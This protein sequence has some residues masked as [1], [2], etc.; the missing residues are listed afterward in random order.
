MRKQKTNKVHHSFRRSYREDYIRETKAPTLMEHA[1]NS[2]KIL[3]KNWRIFGLLLLISIVLFAVLVG[4]MSESTYSRFQAAL[5]S[6]S[7]TSNLGSFARAGLILITAFTTGGFSTSM[8]EVSSVFLV[9]IFLFVWLTTIYFLRQIKNKEKPVF[10]AGLYNSM[11]PL[12]STFSVLC[13]IIIEMIPIFVLTIVYSAA[14]RTNFL[15]TPFYALLFLLFAILLIILTLYLLSSSIIALVAVSAPG[16]YPGV[17]IS[18]ASKLMFSRRTKFIARFLFLLFII[19]V[20]SAV[21]LIPLIM[22]DTA[23]KSANP[24]LAGFPFIPICMLILTVFSFMY[25]ASYL[26]LYYRYLLNYDSKENRNVRQ[27]K[28][29]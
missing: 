13:L 23:I 10:R 8:T 17:A 29:K 11:T 12:V 25:S 5:D 7:E 18:T 26:Y 9:L 24:N 28:S 2:F 14:I 6:A 19:F 16:L 22:I 20:I 1:V 4:L 27:R 21:V 15:S 3:F